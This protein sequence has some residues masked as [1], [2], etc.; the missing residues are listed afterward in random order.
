[1]ALIA[2]VLLVGGFLFFVKVIVPDGAIRQLRE[3]VNKS[4]RTCYLD[5]GRAEFMILNPGHMSFNQV[6]LKT[7]HPGGTE[8]EVSVDRIVSKVSAIRLM[9]GRLKFESI[10]IESPMVVVTD[11]DTPSP[12]Y[13]E[14]NETEAGESTVFTISQ[15]RVHNGSFSYVRNH[16]DTHARLDI[17]DIDATVDELGNSPELMQ[18]EVVGH[19]KAQLEKSGHFE[20]RASTHIFVRPWG[21][22]VEL[23]IADQ[24]L[25]DVTPFFSNNDGVSLKGHLIQGRSTVAVRGEELRA[26]V[27]AKYEGLDV[28]LRKTSDRS[29][30]MAFLS[31]LGEAFTVSPKNTQKVTQ[32][33]TR[34][35]KLKRREGE[36]VVAF[37]LRGMKKAAIKV[38]T[39]V[40]VATPA[41]GFDPDL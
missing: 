41:D 33:Q 18:S 38:A 10:E 5:I 3:S 8:V 21:A 26:E 13:P 14:A 19:A 29:A 39:A 31:N 17:H 32:D 25:E 7:G 15:I 4:C 11:G 34:S 40:T 27:W 23:E 22:D 28:K 30:T 24:N 1:M 9:S 37:I 35:V 6:H 36:S 12:S 16:K 20:L 2:A